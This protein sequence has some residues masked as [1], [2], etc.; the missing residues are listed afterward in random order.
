[1]KAFQSIWIILICICITVRLLILNFFFFLIWKYCSSCPL[2]PWIQIDISSDVKLEFINRLNSFLNS[3]WNLW[4]TV[5]ENAISCY[6]SADI[7]TYLYSADR[8]SFFQMLARFIVIK[9]SPWLC[10]QSEG[11]KRDSQLTDII[12]FSFFDAWLTNNLYRLKHL[13]SL[14][15]AH[16]CLHLLV[17]QRLPCLMF[18]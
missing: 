6:L 7:L 5:D 10:S 17:F 12:Q 11:Q 8:S 1:M 4:P 13:L 16:R 18:Q 3:A 14:M 15:D 2:N 9:R